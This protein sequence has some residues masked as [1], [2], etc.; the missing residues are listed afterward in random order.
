MVINALTGY[1]YSISTDNCLISTDLGNYDEVYKEKSFS[2]NLS[3]MLDDSDNHR[4]FI[5]D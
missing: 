1:L 5:G 3:V 2:N 4:F